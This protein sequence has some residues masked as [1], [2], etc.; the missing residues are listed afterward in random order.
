MSSPKVEARRNAIHDSA[1]EPAPTPGLFKATNFKSTPEPQ[2]ARIGAKEAELAEALETYTTLGHPQYDPKFDAKIRALRPDWF[3]DMPESES[4]SFHIRGL[5]VEVIRSIQMMAAALDIDVA[6]VVTR[7][8]ATMSKSAPANMFHHA[9]IDELEAVKANMVESIAKHRCLPT[10]AA[11]N[12]TRLQ[13]QLISVA[14]DEVANH[15]QFMIDLEW[16]RDDVRELMRT[17]TSLKGSADIDALTRA[18]DEFGLLITSVDNYL[19]LKGR[20]LD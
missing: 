3:E 16:L 5:S 15:H 1:H 4:E 17:L 7:A 6:A 9:L 11:Q 20:E 10:G 19:T 2:P 13:R 12:L 8:V 18:M 14:L